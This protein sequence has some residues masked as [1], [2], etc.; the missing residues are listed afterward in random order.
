VE[1][2]GTGT[3]SNA[4]DS[5]NGKVGVV[6]LDKVDINLA[7]VDNTSDANKPVSSAQLAALNLKANLASQLYWYSKWNNKSN[8]WFNKCR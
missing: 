5:V 6:V 2:T 8:G 3:A 4:V 7:N 1:T